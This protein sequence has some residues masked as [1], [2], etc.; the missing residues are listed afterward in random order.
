MK[1]AARIRTAIRRFSLFEIVRELK[2]PTFTADYVLICRQ[3][4]A[5]GDLKARDLFIEGGER[6]NLKRFIAR[7]K[8]LQLIE[9]RKP[10][11]SILK[12]VRSRG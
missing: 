4:E 1:L 11:A 12:L 9:Q 8:R 3:R 5:Y 6:A 7:T 10:K 2:R